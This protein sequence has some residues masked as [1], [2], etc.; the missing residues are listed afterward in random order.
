MS[1]T[2]VAIGNL[3]REPEMRYTNDGVAVVEFSLACRNASSSKDEPIWLRV[4]TFRGAENHNN[5]LNKGDRVQVIGAVTEDKWTD[6]DGNPRVTWNV[7]ADS[8][9][10]ISTKRLTMD[11]TIEGGHSEVL[12][13]EEEGIKAVT[14]RRVEKAV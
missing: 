14:R 2:V 1:V 11:Q 5:Y 6:R 4:S 13:A 12:T 8:I 9:Q 3:G 10:Y 7:R